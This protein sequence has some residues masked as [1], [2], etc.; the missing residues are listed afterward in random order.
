MSIQSRIVT[1]SDPRNTELVAGALVV[2]LAPAIL[3]K[4]LFSGSRISFTAINFIQL[5]LVAG[6]VNLTVHLGIKVARWMAARPAKRRS[7]RA[8]RSSAVRLPAL[9]TANKRPVTAEPRDEL[10]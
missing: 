4:F 10:R 8:H 1:Q 7:V 2:V 9:S 5:A 6:L 3:V